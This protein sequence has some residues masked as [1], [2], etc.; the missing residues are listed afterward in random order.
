MIVSKLFE[1]GGG[2]VERLVANHPFALVVSRGE[3]DAVHATPLPLIWEPGSTDAFVGHFARAN[4]QVAALKSDPRALA[5]FQG[6]HGY[7]SPSWMQDRTQAPTWNYAT[8]HFEVEILFDDSI[9]AAGAAV[10]QL[11]AH[12]EQGRPA[13]WSPPDMK[14]RFD[15]LVRGVIAFRARIVATRSKFKLGQNER[16]DVLSDILR[17]L[18]RTN[19]PMLASMMRAANRERLEKD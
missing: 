7:I 18:D 2:E 16:L 8:A 3:D 10:S 11:T 15:K 19:E 5:V 14:E 6:P 4:P 12:M 1:V 9:E 13:V 17:G